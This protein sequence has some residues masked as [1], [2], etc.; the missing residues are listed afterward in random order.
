MGKIKALGSS[1]IR[2]ITAPFRLAY[3]GIKKSVIGVW[4]GFMGT[5]RAIIATP[6][7]IFTL[8]GKTYRGL[9]KLRDKVLSIVQYLESETG[10]WIMIWK[11]VKAPYS[12]LR[13]VGL[14]PQSAMAVIGIATV[15]TTTAVAVEALEP[16]KFSDAIAGEFYAPN[17][18]PIFTDERFNTLL[19][20]VSSTPLDSLI[21]S[22]TSLGT[23]YGG[24]LPQGAT[25]SVDISGTSANRLT[26]G[27]LTL[28]RLRC[29]QLKLSEIN[30]NTLRV[31]SNIAD[32]ISFATSAGSGLQTRSR[33]I[34]GGNHSAAILEQAGG[35]YDRFVVQVAN[36][37]TDASIGELTLTDTLT[38]GGLCRLKFIDASVITIKD[39]IIGSGSG[40]NS[41]DFVIEDTVMSQNTYLSGNLEMAVAEPIVRTN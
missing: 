29:K 4:R 21:V 32:G 31:T 12:L 36:G 2:L 23:I 40:I 39:S 30:V 9:K 25:T 8:P 28:D 16:P 5:L 27:E 3:K 34:I 37:I 10:K 33:N 38:R 11:F 15:G 24:S 1:V 20:T 35:T 6:R 7:M 17:D 26:I 19:V 22:S 13:A 14:N 41:K 18:I